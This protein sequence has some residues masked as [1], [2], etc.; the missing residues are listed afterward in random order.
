VKLDPQCLPIVDEESGD[1]PTLKKKRSKREK[2]K[3]LFRHGSKKNSSIRKQS[4]HTA[5]NCSTT[6]QVEFSG[7]LTILLK[8]GRDLVAMD[9]TGTSDPYVVIAPGPSSDYNVLYPGQTAKS[10]VK[11]KTLNPEWNEMLTL[12]IVDVRTD[13]LHVEGMLISSVQNN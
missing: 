13:V 11:K 10:H 1:S 8:R 7:I 6:G 3:A 2:V 5:A 12:S 9:V 4:K